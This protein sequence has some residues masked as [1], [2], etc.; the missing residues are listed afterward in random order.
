MCQNTRL[1]NA[2]C[3]CYSDTR[4]IV[5]SRDELVCYD[6]CAAGG[7]DRFVVFFSR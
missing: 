6:C 1:E 5:F 2:P 7:R 4:E 3:G